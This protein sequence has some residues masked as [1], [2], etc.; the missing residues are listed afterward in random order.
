MSEFEK[1]NV[2]LFNMVH[3][4]HHRSGLSRPVGIIVP[5]DEARKMAEMRAAQSR[6]KPSF[7]EFLFGA[8]FV[9]GIIA[10]TLA[11]AL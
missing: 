2:D 9:L 4:N 3:R 11:A 1:Q 5:I 8:T 7:G 6:K 10:T